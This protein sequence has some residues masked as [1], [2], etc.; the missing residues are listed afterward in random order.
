MGGRGP[1]GGGA[2]PAV[3]LLLLQGAVPTYSPAPL[4]SD[5]PRLEASPPQELEDPQMNPGARETLLNLEVPPPF[6]QERQWVVSSLPSASWRSRTRPLGGDGVRTEPRWRVRLCSHF[7]WLDD[8]EEVVASW[9]GGLW[10]IL[11]S[12]LSCGCMFRVQETETPFVQIA[13]QRFVFVWTTLKC[14]FWVITT[15]QGGFTSPGCGAGEGPGLEALIRIHEDV[16]INN[17]PR[18]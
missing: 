4:H 18:K 14:M 15:Q 5:P 17:S 11:V 1:A 8:G 3:L 9:G 13:S 7:A 2:L 12:C 16:C 6:L 10:L